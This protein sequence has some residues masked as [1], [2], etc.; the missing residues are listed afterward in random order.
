MRNKDAG[1]SLLRHGQRAQP[2][3]D[4][5]GNSRSYQVSVPKSLICVHTHLKPIISS[6]TAVTSPLISILIGFYFVYKR[7]YTTYYSSK[8]PRGISFRG[9][10]NNI[11]TIK[12]YNEDHRSSKKD[13][14]PLHGKKYLK[15]C[16]HFVLKKKSCLLCE[17]A[18]TLCYGIDAPPEENKWGW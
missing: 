4:L 1:I 11:L 18:A 7:R 10:I 17:L 2:N 3:T 13:L 5:W 14:H 12:V 9:M 6:I 8:I 15:P 16:L